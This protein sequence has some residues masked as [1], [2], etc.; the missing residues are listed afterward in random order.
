M[1][2]VHF[3]KVSALYPCIVISSLHERIEN[4]LFT[5]LYTSFG[6]WSRDHYT[7][8]QRF[9]TGVCHALLWFLLT[10]GP[11]CSAKFSPDL[12]PLLRLE[13]QITSCV[14][15]YTT[16]QDSQSISPLISKQVVSYQTHG[17][18]YCP[19]VSTPKIWSL[20]DSSNHIT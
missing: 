15:P 2:V 1:I 11:A 17:G 13:G 6:V 16:E 20:A 7:S 19:G 14:F 3:A 5:I 9:T 4:F 10:L 8:L 12:G 18:T